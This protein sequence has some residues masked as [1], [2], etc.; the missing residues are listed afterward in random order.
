MRKIY[1]S[2]PN[3]SHICG[4]LAVRKIGAKLCHLKKCTALR[5]PTP[6]PCY[7]LP[8]NSYLVLPGFHIIQPFPLFNYKDFS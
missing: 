7:L 2:P 1:L 8:S 3:I 4:G 6:V 5:Y